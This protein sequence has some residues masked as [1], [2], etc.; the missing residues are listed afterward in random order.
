M[1]HRTTVRCRIPGNAIHKKPSP[2]GAGRRLQ[3]NYPNCRWMTAI[4]QIPEA[5]AKGSNIKETATLSNSISFRL[6]GHLVLASSE[7][8]AGTL[9]QIAAGAP[10]PK[11]KTPYALL[12]VPKKTNLYETIRYRRDQSGLLRDRSV[13]YAAI[14]SLKNA[15]LPSL[16]KKGK[17]EGEGDAHEEDVAWLAQNLKVEYLDGM[18]VLRISLTAGT[19]REQALLANAIAHAYFRLEVR[20]EQEGFE[21]I[22]GSLQE[23]ENSLTKA[24]PAMN[25]EEKKRFE[26]HFVAVKDKIKVIEGEIRTL[27]RLLELAEVPPE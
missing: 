3:A 17:G 10:A 9:L 15:H 11:P 23:Q 24:L 2:E 18:G 25:G 8:A 14:R 5:L 26:G 13:L 6:L 20:R 7:L 12:F 21:L 27:P 19:R 1:S 22:L 4:G 16:P